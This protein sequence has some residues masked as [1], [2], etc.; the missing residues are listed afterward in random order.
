VG[1][2]PFTLD[3]FVRNDRIHAVR[4]GRDRLN[5][6][7]TNGGTDFQS[8]L[9]GPNENTPNITNPVSLSDGFKVRD[10]RSLRGGHCVGFNANNQTERST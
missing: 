6:V 7:T 1:L 8:V 3:A 10:C 5:A 2:F 4:V 9:A